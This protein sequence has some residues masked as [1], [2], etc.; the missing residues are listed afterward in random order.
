M[1]IFRIALL[2]SVRQI[3]RTSHW[4]TALIILVMM[5][6]FLNLIAVSGILVGL[7]TGAERAVQDRLLGDVL[8]SAHTDEKHI[9]NTHTIIG[10][11]ET[12][13]RV[14][15]FSIRYDSSGVLEAN[16]RTRRDLSS[17]R[18]IVNAR[19]VGIDPAAEQAV[20]SLADTVIDGTYFTPGKQDEILIG[21]MLI[22]RYT[23]DFPDMVDSL[24]DVQPGDTVRLTI[25]GTTKEFV[26]AG[27]IDAKVGELTSSAF[28]HE[29]QLR[30]LAGRT[31]RNA[32]R[33]S[34]RTQKPEQAIAVQ[35][36]LLALGY[37]DY[38]QIQ[39]FSEALPKFIVDIKETFRILANF[40]GAVGIIVA[41]ITI[42][43]IVFINALSR[44]REIGILK[45]IG[46]DQ[47]ALQLAYVLQATFYVIVGS[48]LGS[49][50][51]YGWLI[52][53]FERNPLDFPF[54]D[55]VLVAPPLETLIRF[56]ILFCVTLAAGFVPA[57]LIC[58]Q[59]TLDAI[60]GRK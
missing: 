28:I 19:I 5:L 15:A 57:W 23:E 11:L 31:D 32:N 17:D 6:T 26:I 53:Y 45:G 55:G 51:I 16:Y 24:S 35:N 33:I 56:I 2:L 27:I 48:L 18:D 59:N 36:S 13:P 40:I 7:I 4:T 47:R 34:L 30:R 42:F 44:R 25:Q 8:I 10:A 43:I 1:H 29:Q 37:G 21:T 49:L 52:G 54:S 60:L 14:R 58:R 20:G 38:A 12:D 3:Q 46:I 41:S 9:I 50:I 39:T 22:K